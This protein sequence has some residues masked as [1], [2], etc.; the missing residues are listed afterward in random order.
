MNEMNKKKL[1]IWRLASFL[2]SHQMSMSGEEL[3]THLNRNNFMTSYG[4]EFRGGRGTYKL[5]TAT[6]RWVHDDL[7]LPDE[8]EH[9]AKAFVNSE[10]GY[11]YEKD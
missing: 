10:G 11:P 2:H 7:G 5:I 6:W 8:A 4:K 9:I 1:Y 3:A